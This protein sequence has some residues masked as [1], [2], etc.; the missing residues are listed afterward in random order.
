[1]GRARERA[2]AR[3]GTMATERAARKVKANR[4][5]MIMMTTSMRQRGR[6]KAKAKEKE[7]T[8]PRR[9]AKARVRAKAKAK[10]TVIG[11][12]PTTRQKVERRAARAKVWIKE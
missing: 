5:T 4:C 6:Q 2:R 3:I 12:T 1:M 8:L 9:R 11:K 10:N 7:K